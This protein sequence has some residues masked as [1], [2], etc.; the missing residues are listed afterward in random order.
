MGADHEPVINVPNLASLD[1]Q[2][3][4]LVSPGLEVPDDSSQGID[5]FIF[6][7]LY[8]EEGTYQTVA[9]GEAQAMRMPNPLFV[10][11]PHPTA[12][13]LAAAPASMAP[14]MT[15]GDAD[16]QG[17]NTYRVNSIDEYR[18]NEFS[19]HRH[20]EGNGNS[21][22][23]IAA[24]VID[25]WGSSS[26][27]LKKSNGKWSSWIELASVIP[28][29]IHQSQNSGYLFSDDIRISDDFSSR[30]QHY[31][32]FNTFERDWSKSEKRLI[33]ATVYGNEFKQDG[34]RRYLNEWYTF[35]QASHLDVINDGYSFRLPLS[36]LHDVGPVS[37]SNIRA[38]IEFKWVD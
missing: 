27:V 19:V 8:T 11:S 35:D 4:P 25:P 20:F 12:Q 9:V 22:F 7:W 5:D 2:A 32:L 6:S 15:V 29:R 1:V 38:H 18:T 28:A 21:E 31:L 36:T 10:V 37:F 26:R 34:K 14:T 13:A 3:L 30:A 23:C 16:S 24:L 17:P 33:R